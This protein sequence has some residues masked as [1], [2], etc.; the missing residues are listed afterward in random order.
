MLADREQILGSA[1]PS[2]LISRGNLANIYAQA[3]RLSEANALYE[4][5]VAD[6]KRILSASHPITREIR[7]NYEN[8]KRWQPP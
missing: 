1:H 8:A 5:A 4:S 2:T 3:G 6:C 7:H